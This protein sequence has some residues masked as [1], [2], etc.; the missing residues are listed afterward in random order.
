MALT[1]DLSTEMANLERE[2]E[3]SMVRVDIDRHSPWRGG[4]VLEPESRRLLSTL[5]SNP[6]A[7]LGRADRSNPWRESLRQLG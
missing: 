4:D 5:A 3:A 7:G 6:S 2:L 1:D